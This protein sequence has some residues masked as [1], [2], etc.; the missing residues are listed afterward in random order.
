MKVL[1]IGRYKSLT[2]SIFLLEKIS[3]INLLMDD[4]VNEKFIKNLC[5][6]TKII[7]TES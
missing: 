6:D 2:N 4:F 7:L 3:R 5:Y 1:K